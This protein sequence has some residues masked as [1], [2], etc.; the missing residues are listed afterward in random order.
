[1]VLC[2][3]GVW[4]IFFE[5]LLVANDFLLEDFSILRFVTNG[6][7]YWELKTL[8]ETAVCLIDFSYDSGGSPPGFLP[9]ASGSFHM[10]EELLWIFRSTR[11]IEIGQFPRTSGGPDVDTCI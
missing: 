5:I 2:L 10:P 9:Y 11:D 4:W 1:M 8:Y 3:Y 6:H 7:S